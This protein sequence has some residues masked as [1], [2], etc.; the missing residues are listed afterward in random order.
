[1][2]T[3]EELLA[4]VSEDAPSGE[5]MD[6][7]IE[8]DRLRTAFEINF[9]IDARVVEL[10]E[11]DVEPAAVD[12]DELLELIEELS[13]KTKDLFLGVSYA[14]CGFVVRDPEVVDR[15]LQFAA[16]LLEEHWDTVHP[17]PDS[18]YGPAGRSLI[19]EDLAKRG[20]FA[21]PFLELPIIDDG[22]SRVTADQ[23]REAEDL[24]ASSDSYPDVMRMLDQM[25]DEAK[26]AIVDLLGS[27]SSSIDRIETAL[28]EK[29]EGEVPDFSTTRDFIGVVQTAFSK[30]AGLDAGEDGEAADG[31]EASADP[32]SGGG[33][34]GPAFSGSIKSRDDVLKALSAIEQYYARAEPGHP[35]KVAA[36]RL[37]GWVTKDFMEI[38]ADIVPGSVDEAKNVLLERRDEE[39]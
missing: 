4:P 3:L 23:L 8:F 6:E 20:A 15:G 22:R 31:D 2:K 10:D 16:G 38:L 28:K 35:V 37:R 39:W 7:S 1:M 33:A 30:L 9:P 32:G 21:L 18:D 27:Y 26:T 34:D 24:G 25:D 12:W 36:G 5:D 14:R 13:E 11:G 17:T 29:G 19:F